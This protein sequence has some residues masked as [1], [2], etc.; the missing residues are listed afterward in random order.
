[1]NIDGDF[2]KN[3]LTSDEVDATDE[4]IKSLESHK[5][6]SHKNLLEFQDINQKLHNREGVRRGERVITSD[7]SGQYKTTA[8]EIRFAAHLKNLGVVFEYEVPGDNNKTI[9]FRV[10]TPHG[11]A[12]LELYKKCTSEAENNNTYTDGNVSVYS[13]DLNQNY[14]NPVDVADILQ[15]QKNIATD[16][17]LKFKENDNQNINILIIDIRS[18]NHGTSDIHDA[19]AILDK[20][21]V[22]PEFRRTIEPGK[23]PLHGIFENEHPLFNKI[24]SKVDGIIII[25]GDTYGDK[26]FSSNQATTKVNP[27]SRKDHT[28]I[29]NIM[30]HILPTTKS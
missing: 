30:E 26:E 15:I 14:R 29:Q 9:D 4:A 18:I 28:K 1:M 5:L 21:Y 7:Q 10:N 3:V 12:Q 16:K 19:H 11:S 25:Y 22:P 13:A 27:H 8:F 17:V 20:Q 2:T 6:L 23:Q 24:K